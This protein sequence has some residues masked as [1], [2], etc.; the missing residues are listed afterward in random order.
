MESPD[1][2]KIGL[3]PIERET[4]LLQPVAVTM[5]RHDYSRLQV[6]VLECLVEYM[7]PKL[8]DI[9]INRKSVYE[10]FSS[11][12]FDNDGRVSIPIYF[13]DL[14]VEPDKDLF[15]Y[16]E[17]TDLMDLLKQIMCIPVEIPHK[18]QY[19]IQYLKITNLA[20]VFISD[21]DVSNGYAIFKIDMH[22][23]EPL[24]SI[25]LGYHRLGKEVVL[26][27]HEGYD[28]IGVSQHIYMMLEC[29]IRKGIVTIPTR[30]FLMSM[31]L[32]NIFST[33]NQFAKSVLEP[34]KEELYNLAVNGYSDC[35]FSYDRKYENEEDYLVFKIFR[36]DQIYAYE[37][38]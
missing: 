3:V 24:F 11:E 34:V 31:R 12:D 33:Y 19:G 20:D 10:A 36:C 6:K 21:N 15:Y 1:K 29:W 25:D 14:N 18:T 5:M 30:E 17:K 28:G 13:K 26:A 38:A 32:E 8:R 35:Y 16:S 27:C 4:W 7:Q 9:I 23:M 2:N 37:N 22:V